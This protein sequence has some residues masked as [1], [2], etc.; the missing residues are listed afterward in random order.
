MRLSRPSWT[1]KNRQGWETS[2]DENTWSQN[3]KLLFNNGDGGSCAIV[4]RMLWT[5][6][7]ARLILGR[8]VC[9]SIYNR[10][11]DDRSIRLKQIAVVIQQRSDGN[12]FISRMSFE[13]LD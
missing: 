3:G 12:L 1:A 7:V 6:S 8:R 2:D 11:C 5:C 9:A 13:L 4:G 10:D